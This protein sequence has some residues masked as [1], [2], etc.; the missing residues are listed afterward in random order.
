MR[1]TRLTDR[2][3]AN[4]IKQYAQKVGL[5]PADYSGHS[6]RR[7]GITAMLAGGAATFDVMDQSG[8]RR[9]ETL[10]KYNDQA[11]QGAL[12]AVRSAFGEKE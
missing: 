5:D 4:L 3:I 12:R 11:G 2:S 1:G 9:V 7:G 10:R 6:A 8:H